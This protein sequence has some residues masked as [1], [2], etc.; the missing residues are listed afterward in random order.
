MVEW[1]GR[2]PPSPPLDPA[3]C[4]LSVPV[5]PLL[6]LPIFSSLILQAPVEQS[7]NF[8]VSVAATDPSVADS[9]AGERVAADPA[10]RG[11]DGAGREEGLQEGHPLRPPRQAAAEGRLHPAQV[12]LREGLRSPQ[13]LCLAAPAPP[14]LCSHLYVEERTQS[15]LSD[16]SRFCLRLSCR[17]PGTGSIQRSGSGKSW[18]APDK[19]SRSW[20]F[21]F[22]LFIFGSI[23][24]E[25]NLGRKGTFFSSSLHVIFY[26][27]PI[28]TL[29]SS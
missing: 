24:W 16:P 22:Y 13:G 17:R 19:S 7:F 2:E 26:A 15:L 10:D 27:C 21:Y 3:I 4:E 25:S 12:H 8:F 6:L 18:R 11:P 1:K 9:R 23:A 20:W 5:S 29:L 14:P 28:F